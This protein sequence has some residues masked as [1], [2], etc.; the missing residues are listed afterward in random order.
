VDL[1]IRLCVSGTW[2]ISS[3]F[4]VSDKTGYYSNNSRWRIDILLSSM[5]DAAAAGGASS[6]L[7]AF[8]KS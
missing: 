3:R 5:V 1:G 2:F 4:R 7:I 8:D 6:N